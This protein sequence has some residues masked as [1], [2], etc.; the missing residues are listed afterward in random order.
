MS[1][2]PPERRPEK[3]F[4]KYRPSVAHGGPKYRILRDALIAA[5]EDGYW[6]VGDRLPTELELTAMTPYSLG[7][8]QRAIQALVAEGFVTRKPRSGSFVA[9]GHRRIGGPWLFRFLAE[10][11]SGF[12]PMFTKVVARRQVKERGQWFD[13]LTQGE[14]RKRLLRIDRHIR[15]DSELIAFNRVYLDPQRYPVIAS[16]PTRELDGANFV[17]MIEHAYRLPVNHIAHTV[18]C[19]MLPEVARRAIGLKKRTL[20]TIVEIAASAGRS[21]PV[22]YQQIFVPPTAY[23]L[24]ISETSAD[25]HTTRSGEPLP[26]A[27]GA[28][29]G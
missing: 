16:A 29:S 27:R 23:R 19:A 6:E 8:V 9:P 3:F 24:Y 7:T 13:W 12:L 17:H 10:D 2:A 28:A 26:E 22:S 15:V 1:P 14:P 20:G 4:A 11:G 25:W 21:R 18:R 5:I